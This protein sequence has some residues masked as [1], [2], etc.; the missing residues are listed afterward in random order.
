MPVLE[1][2]KA[3]DC[4]VMKRSMASGLR[5][6]RQSAVLQGQHPMLFGDAR[7]SVTS[8]LTALRA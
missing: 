1:V 6:R 2:W 5:R 8:V 3:D 4:I 7:Q